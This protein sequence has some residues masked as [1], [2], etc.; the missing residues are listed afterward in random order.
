MKSL[1]IDQ[2]QARTNAEKPIVLGGRSYAKDDIAEALT[3]RLETLTLHVGHST[4]IDM[5]E[6]KGLK[7]GMILHPQFPPDVF[8]EGASYR[9]S[10][11][12][13]EHQGHRAVLNA[14]ERLSN[15]YAAEGEQI[16]EKLDIMT[17]QLRD[18]QGRLDQPFDHDK[19]LAEMTEL[20]DQLKAALSGRSEDQAK[21]DIPTASELADRI[22][23][24]K[25][26]HTVDASPQRTSSRKTSAAIPIST[27]IRN[28]KEVVDHN[29]EG[30]SDQP[31]FV[32]QIIEPSTV[33][34]DRLVQERQFTHN[35]G[36]HL[37]S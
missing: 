16:K 10:T 13:R 9:Q 15:S 26:S 19:Y 29:W 12:S 33:F 25:A 8:L 17:S 30:H 36:W 1:A 4:R 18:Y 6:Y 32:R 37:G 7:F 11:L 20:R 22:K 31:F 14:L 27:R 2:N 35:P 23:A 28:Q 34:Q 5:G 3:N 21:A 24:L